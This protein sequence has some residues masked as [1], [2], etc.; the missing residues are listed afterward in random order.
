MRTSTPPTRRGRITF[1]V[2]PND[3]AALT[4][5]AE[6]VD[7]DENG[8]ANFSGMVKD[9]RLAAPPLAPEHR[10]M[11]CAM[12]LAAPIRTPLASTARLR[13]IRTPAPW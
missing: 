3:R 7:I 12:M 10:A 8:F 13:S 5:S 2:L 1:A 4:V 9:A 6:Y 11:C